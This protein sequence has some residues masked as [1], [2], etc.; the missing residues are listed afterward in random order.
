MAGDQRKLK[1]TMQEMPIKVIAEGIEAIY[2]QIL[3]DEKH[4]KLVPILKN[5]DPMAY[6]DQ[7]ADRLGDEKQSA[8]LGSYNEQRKMWN[9]TQWNLTNSHLHF[10]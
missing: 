3:I 5:I 10:R 8:V 6:Y 4:G 7:F 2:G 9:T 1:P